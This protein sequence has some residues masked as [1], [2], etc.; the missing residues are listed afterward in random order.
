[1]A[2]IKTKIEEEAFILLHLKKMFFLSLKAVGC[3]KE[4]F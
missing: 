1:M 2:L 4:I 3:I